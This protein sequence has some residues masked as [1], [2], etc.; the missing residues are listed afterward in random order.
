MSTAATS[1][2]KVSASTPTPHDRRIRAKLR[3]IT[4]GRRW[5]V[6]TLLGYAVT[7]LAAVAGIAVAAKIGMPWPP[8][9]KHPDNMSTWDLMVSAWDGRWYS[10][11]IEDGYPTDLPRDDFGNVTQNPWAFY[12]IF[13][14]SARL[15]S[16]VTR[17]PTDVAGILLVTLAGLA[18]VLLLRR[19]LLTVQ[20][21]IRARRPWFLFTAPLALAAFP[22]AAVF[23]TTYSDS[24]AIAFLISA[25]ILLVRRRYFWF[26][27]LALVLG[28]ARPLAVPLGFVV[29]VHFWPYIVGR[30]RRERIVAWTD[31]G[32]FVLI[33]VTCLAS[34][35]LWPAIAGVV[36][37]EPGALF[38]TQGAWLRP[39]GSDPT[40][41]FS[42]WMASAG[43]YLRGTLSLAIFLGLFI[44]AFH[45][46]SVR[47]FGREI[48]AWSCGYLLFLTATVSMGASTPRYLLAALSLH[49]VLAARVTRAWHALLVLGVLTVLQFGW[50][51]AYYTTPALT[52]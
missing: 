1:N 27:V 47:E 30:L 29:I 11:I 24:L 44:L 49:L 14:V 32:W 41:P 10:M 12:P 26:C 18:A 19:F 20:P 39:E 43:D 23:S 15:I 8:E 13:P 9:W 7:R 42:V 5:W 36:T 3:D 6:G 22:A 4:L 34:V 50:A 17:I 46:R 35:G 31:V 37:G 52:P 21:D 16:T 25:I 45:T 38:S 2:A 48:F 51:V 28:L 40:R 33:G